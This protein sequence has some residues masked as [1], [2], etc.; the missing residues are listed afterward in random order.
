MVHCHE[1]KRGDIFYCDHCGLE[2][3]VRTECTE[4][5]P[6]E[7]ECACGTCSFMCCDAELKKKT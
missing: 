2:L 1:M 3:E 5:E 7:G 6:T 4:C